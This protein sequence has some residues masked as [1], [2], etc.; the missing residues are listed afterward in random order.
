MTHGP[1][2]TWELSSS[3]DKYLRAIEPARED[4]RVDVYSVLDAFAVT[5][6][7]IQHAAKKILCSG[8]RG[9]GSALQDL[10][11]ARDALDRAIQMERARCG[12]A[13]G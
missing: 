13:D 9:K 12:G 8:I 11:E 10:T 4:G 6:P 1:H 5:C 7:A 3:G 2:N